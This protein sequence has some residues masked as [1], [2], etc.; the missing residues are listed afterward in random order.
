MT[1]TAGASIAREV[2]RRRRAA[3]VQALRGV[4]IEAVRDID[5][6]MQGMA[7]T[8]EDL[9]RRSQWSTVIARCV[10]RY[11]ELVGNLAAAGSLEEYGVKSR[12][13]LPQLIAGAQ[14]VRVAGNESVIVIDVEV[15][16]TQ[17]MAGGAVVD[18]WADPLHVD[19]GGEG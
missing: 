11:R 16:A 1:K 2:N 19:V 13:D 10:E 15:S 17:I 9:D 18:G 7:I 14:M 4:A 3:L 6:E 12:A 5:A 8:A